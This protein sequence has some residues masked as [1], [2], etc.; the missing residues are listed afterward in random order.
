MN[1]QE[2]R[3]DLEPYFKKHKIY[4][5][6]LL[7]EDE[8]LSGAALSWGTTKD[9]TSLLSEKKDEILDEIGVQK[10]AATTIY[11]EKPN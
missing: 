9:L 11:S 8:D 5:F 1:L 6:I 7:L 4:G 3:N 10:L 2:L